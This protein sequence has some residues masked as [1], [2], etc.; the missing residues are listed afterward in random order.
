MVLRPPNTRWIILAWWLGERSY[1]VS[2]RGHSVRMCS[3]MGNRNFRTGTQFAFPPKRRRRWPTKTKQNS[4]QITTVRW[5]TF[6][7]T[8]HTPA[9]YL[10]VNGRRRLQKRSLQ[11]NSPQD[12]LHFHPFLQRLLRFPSLPLRFVA[13]FLVRYATVEPG[14]LILHVTQLPRWSQRPSTRLWHDVKV[15]DSGGFGRGV[16]WE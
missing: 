15:T 9:V 7:E 10:I 3:T 12:T 6:R 14:W 8:S 13:E 2:V 16:L 4:H 1:T 5:I 11:V